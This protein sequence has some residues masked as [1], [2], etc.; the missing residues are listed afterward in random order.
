MGRMD[1][2]T[3]GFSKTVP[4]SHHAG[5]ELSLGTL[6][7]GSTSEVTNLPLNAIAVLAQH[8]TDK[9]SLV[10]VVKAGG[11]APQVYLAQPAVSILGH[12]N[13]VTQGRD[14]LNLD[15]H[16]LKKLQTTATTKAMTVVMTRND[17]PIRVRINMTSIALTLR[18]AMICQGR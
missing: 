14:I 6:T 7:L 16:F 12:S 3:R 11:H 4:V 17:T 10:V 8:S 18:L 13:L 1:F 5:Y 9:T 2:Y 15:S